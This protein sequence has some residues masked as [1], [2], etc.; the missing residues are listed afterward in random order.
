MALFNGDDIF[1]FEVVLT[2]EDLPRQIQRTGFFGVDGVLGIDGGFRGR[3]A[4]A[5]GKLEADSP[6]DLGL[7]KGIFRTYRDG[8]QYALIDDEGW[9]WLATLD[10]FY[11]HG[12]VELNAATGLYQQYYRAEFF[13][14]D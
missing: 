6:E 9:S 1:G 8:N 14:F 11:P 13:V 5:T 2:V 4:H 3:I 7:L 12:R 10:G